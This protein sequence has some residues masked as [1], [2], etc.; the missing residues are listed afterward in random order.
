MKCTILHTVG[1][2][3]GSGLA[4]RV[5]LLP[6]WLKSYSARNF[7]R[8]TIMEPT[9]ANMQ[10]FATV[11]SV[12][13]WAQLKGD[14]LQALLNILGVEVDDHLALSEVIGTMQSRSCL[15]LPSLRRRL[16]SQNGGGQGA[17]VLTTTIDVLVSSFLSPQCA[18]CVDW[19]RA[20][21]VQV[22]H[23]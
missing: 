7:Q 18:E 11:Q 1:G 8:A 13:L 9:P 15:R 17:A 20:W 6:F 12:F 3:G 10:S 19:Y 23:C 16:K 2:W 22:Q 21:E 4:C 5:L 14:S